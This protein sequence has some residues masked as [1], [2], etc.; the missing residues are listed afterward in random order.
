[1][2]IG[3]SL[4]MLVLVA[5]CG[6]P[7]FDAAHAQTI[8]VGQPR[9]QVRATMGP[10]DHMEKTLESPKSCVERWSYGEPTREVFLVDFDDQGRV[11]DVVFAHP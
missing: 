2:V 1:M 3:R 11:C 8:M 9:D 10:P 5:A 4:V 6:G 7:P